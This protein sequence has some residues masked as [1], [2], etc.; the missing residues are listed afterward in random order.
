M[1][2]EKS[3]V[4][5]F[6]TKKEIEALRITA[7]LY[8]VLSDHENINEDISFLMSVKDYADLSDELIAIAHSAEQRVY[9]SNTINFIEE[10]I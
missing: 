8:K 1:R 2:E 3:A 5:I 7:E 9:F 10:K 4:K 6:L